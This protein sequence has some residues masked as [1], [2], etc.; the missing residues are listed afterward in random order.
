MV[1]KYQRGKNPS[2]IRTCM[3]MS[4]V[5]AAHHKKL[6]TWCTIS[7]ADGSLWSS[8][9]VALAHRNLCN[10]DLNLRTQCRTARRDAMIVMLSKQKGVRTS[11]KVTHTLMLFCFSGLTVRD[12]APSQLPVWVLTWRPPFQ[13]DLHVVLD[14]VMGQTE[15]ET[16]PGH[17]EPEAI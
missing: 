5:I 7:G 13:Q 3:I 17:V 14:Q 2:H 9:M 15:A 1:V 16:V 11:Y 12:R 6:C 10:A 8:T 4:Q